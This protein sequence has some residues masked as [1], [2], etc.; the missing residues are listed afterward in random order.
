MKLFF[1][2]NDGQA[3]I[4]FI[5]S[6]SFLLFFLLFFLTVGINLAVGYVVH[7]AVFKA[8]RT[9]LTHDNGD[10]RSSVLSAAKTKALET[11]NEFAGLNLKGTLEI[12][13]PE[14]TPIYE[15]VGAYYLYNPS[16]KAV[17]PF[18][19]G[20]DYQFLSESFLG[21]EPSRSECRCQTQLALGGVCLSDM[22]D[23]IE[24]TVY[25]NGC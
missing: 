22:S 21:K 5:F 20:E 7:Y 9:Y 15:F 14:S 23:E 18:S 19:L 12:N 3:T 1:K 4:E 25:D 2:K 11:F 24:V 17:G 6:F 16:I 13:S 8:S 10:T